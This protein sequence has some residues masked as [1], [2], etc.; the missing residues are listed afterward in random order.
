MAAKDSAASVVEIELLE[1]SEWRGVII[2]ANSE[3]T[4]DHDGAASFA[5]CEWGITE[6]A[7]IT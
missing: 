3:S 1:S 2:E 5:G 6:E 7:T 4:S